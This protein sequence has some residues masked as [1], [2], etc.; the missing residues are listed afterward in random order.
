MFDITADLEEEICFLEQDAGTY[1][2]VLSALEHEGFQNTAA[3]D[4]KK[5]YTFARRFPAYLPALF[6]VHRDL[7][8]RAERMNEL[9]SELYKMRKAG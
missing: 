4:E 9:I 8:M 3:F 5:A 2:L 7:Q 6:L 1:N